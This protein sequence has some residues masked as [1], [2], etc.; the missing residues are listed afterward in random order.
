MH[1]F[2]SIVL[3]SGL[4][5]FCNT[6]PVNAR[7]YD[8]RLGRWITIDK[9]LPDYFIDKRNPRHNS[10]E[11]E[12]LRDLPGRGGI[13]N[14]F[15]LN[16]YQYSFLNP[17]R[18]TDPD[19]NQVAIPFLSG[20]EI[21]IGEDNLYFKPAIESA[22]PE[23][24]VKTE[25]APKTTP[26]AEIVPKSIPKTEIKPIDKNLDLTN[27]KTW[28]KPPAD[29]PLKEG[30]PSRAKPAQRGEKSLFDKNGGEWRPHKPD[31]FH[32]E[33]HWDYKPAGKNMEWKDIP[34]QR[35]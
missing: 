32:P 16:L 14:P 1:I 26:K 30:I 24:L 31:R 20:P 8:P 6:S 5:L 19:G 12:P 10:D 22:K 4:F 13:Y 27:T 21:I 11:F 28:P 23:E 17:I 9:A 15:N 25:T 33:G 3:L 7:Y 2:S 29:G 34:V 18:F 35:K